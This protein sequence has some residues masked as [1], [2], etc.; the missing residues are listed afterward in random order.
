MIRKL[1]IVL[2]VVAL[3]LLLIEAKCSKV[4]NDARDA[5]AALKGL[6]TSAQSEYQA[7][8]QSNPA[9]AVC[10]TINRGVAGQNA[11][12]TSVQAYCGWS[13]SVPPDNPN[14]PCVPVKGTESALS[15][16]VVNANEL[17]TELKGILKQ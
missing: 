16:A 1:F 12:I 11:L 14:A 8:C 13:A 3:S 7:T 15:A 6:I 10:Q 17:I 4:Q 9:Q 2:S 5:A